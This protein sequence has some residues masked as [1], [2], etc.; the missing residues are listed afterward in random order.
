[1]KEILSGICPCSS[2]SLILPCLVPN[3]K[4]A[5]MNANDLGRVYFIK[6]FSTIIQKIH[7]IGTTFALLNNAGLFQHA[8]ESSGL[9][10][11]E[12]SDALEERFLSKQLDNLNLGK[13]TEYTEWN[14]DNGSDADLF[15]TDEE[16]VEHET[17]N[18]K[19]HELLSVAVGKVCKED[20][21]DN[22][23]DKDSFYEDCENSP[24]CFVSKLETEERSD[25]SMLCDISNENHD[26]NNK[27]ND[28]SMIEEVIL[29]VVDTFFDTENENHDEKEN[30]NIS[31]CL[32][33]TK[34]SEE[35]SSL[36][37]EECEEEEYDEE[38][39]DIFD[40][41]SDT[42]EESYSDPS[43]QADIENS[44]EDEDEDNEHS[45]EKMKKLKLLA[46]K[47]M[48]VVQNTSNLSVMESSTL[49]FFMSDNGP[50]Q[51]QVG[52]N[53]L[54]IYITFVHLIILPILSH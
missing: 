40:E 17:K 48:S 11:L 4:A 43:W 21:S 51:L 53:L 6:R 8:D 5:V 44:D 46:Q 2:V 39:S 24:N 14:N 10:P 54:N 16:L 47:N 18:Q 20:N 29:E 41:E 15:L 49:S 19:S 36:D 1:M 42:D 7:V 3:G 25:K 12:K 9:L 32:T 45:K 30:N 33:L 26:G 35:E 13:R 27:S 52:A 37:D 28:Y 50:I 23:D 38:D 34:S 22:G 31:Q